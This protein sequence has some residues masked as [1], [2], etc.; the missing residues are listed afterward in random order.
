MEQARP[1]GRSSDAEKIPLIQPPDYYT[2]VSMEDNP[3]DSN[4]NSIEDLSKAEVP[5]ES[6][7]IESGNL[8]ADSNETIEFYS[9]LDESSEESAAADDMEPDDVNHAFDEKVDESDQGQADSFISDW[10]QPGTESAEFNFEDGEL[11]ESNSTSEKIPHEEAG[12]YDSPVED[13]FDLL[14]EQDAADSAAFHT[15]EEILPDTENMKE[16]ETEKME[17]YP[18]SQREAEGGSASR[19]PEKSEGDSADLWQ[20]AAE[21]LPLHQVQLIEWLFMLPPDYPVDYVY[22]DRAAIKVIRFE[23]L[24]T[25]ERLANFIS[26][27]G[28]VS[29]PFKDINGIV[30]PEDK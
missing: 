30:F 28:L 23:G 7:D 14:I 21:G 1:E 2:L 5:D 4:V 24:N 10:E 19:L 18:G 9:N 8:S 15:T 25:A 12:D 13:D 16:T 22:T 29:I 3:S 6:A 11:I 17:E 26:K 27:D 20:L